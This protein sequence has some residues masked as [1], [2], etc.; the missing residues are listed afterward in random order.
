MREGERQRQKHK[1]KERKRGINLAKSHRY[2]GPE[3]SEECLTNFGDNAYGPVG[4]LYL[5]GQSFNLLEV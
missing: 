1:K 5:W 2:M 3:R 4:L